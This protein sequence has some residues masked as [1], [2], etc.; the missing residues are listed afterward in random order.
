MTP[1][2]AAVATAASTALPPLLQRLDAGRGGVRVHAG[3][4]AA[5]ADGDGCL[6]GVADAAS[7]DGGAAT[8]A[9]RRGDQ[10]RQRRSG[11]QSGRPRDRASIHTRNSARTYLSVVLRSSNTVPRTA[12]DPAGNVCP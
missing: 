12:S 4:R 5:V 8:V 10:R 7:A 6:V 2:A 1:R 9:R 11:R 3:N